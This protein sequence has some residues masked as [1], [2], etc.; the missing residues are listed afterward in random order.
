MARLG[1]TR[2]C[3]RSAGT[4]TTGAERCNVRRIS[5][6]KGMSSMA[7]SMNTAADTLANAMRKVTTTLRPTDV[8]VNPTQHATFDANTNV[9]AAIAL[10]EENEDLSNDEFSDAAECIT[11]NPMIATVYIAMSNQNSRSRYIRKQVNSY[12]GLEAA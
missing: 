4:G 7:N 8:T 3:T 9:P 5:A 6:G 12:R 11:R 2:K 1:D 10:I